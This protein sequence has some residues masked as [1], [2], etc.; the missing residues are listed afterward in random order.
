MGEIRLVG[1]AHVSQNSV[2][3]V[4]R[5]IEEFEPDVVAI[6]L[7]QGRYAALKKEG[8]KATVDDILKGGNFSEILVQWMLAYI[9][10]KIG[11]DVG[12]EPGAEM[13]AAMEEAEGRNIPIA[14]AD[15]DIRLTLSRFWKGMSLWEKMKLI[16]ALAGTVAGRGG[17]E[18]IDVEALTKDKDLIEA[19]IEEF[20]NFSPRG[21]KALIDERDAYLSHSLL[22]LA[23]HNE[24]VLGVVGA[25]HVKGI[26]G[27]FNDPSKLPPFASL[28][29]Q[30]KT[31]PWKYIFGGLFIAMFAFLMILI[32][33]S[34]VGI[35][36]LI[37]AIVY[38]VL[39]NGILAGGFT[40]IAGGHPLSAVTAFGVSWMTSLNPLLAAGW[41]AAITEAK[42]RK[43]K[44]S[45]LQ[46]IVE[47]E[48]FT[49]MR[50][51][52]LFRVVL[53]AALANVGSTIGT[54]AYFIFI[55][56]ILGIDPTVVLAD[57]FNNLM[58]FLGSL[59]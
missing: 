31:L 2:D 58:A 41:F 44:T 24:K 14:L 30:P 56:P 7:D 34:G 9:Q 18:E 27:Y 52:P 36:V 23:Q 40:L 6:E 49:E 15:R 26:T 21:A 4:R 37:W 8:P 20:H 50:K 29:E 46:K 10:K 1:T 38:W 11:M 19:A 25:G 12:V 59:I 5:A 51:V 54:F 57:G 3:E 53:V 16:G 47:A 42:V 45:D 28:V 48:N 13:M 39:I 17:D 35:D 33:F 43:P 32:G 22:R 55:F